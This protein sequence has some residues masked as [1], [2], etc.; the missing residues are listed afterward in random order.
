MFLL[1]PLR[2]TIETIDHRPRVGLVEKGFPPLPSLL[3]WCVKLFTAP[4]NI[5]GQITKRR[6]LQPG[7]RR[8]ERARRRVVSC[9]SGI[10]GR[11]NSCTTHRPKL[12]RDQS[13]NIFQFICFSFPKKK[14]DQD[15][16]SKSDRKDPQ[17]DAKWGCSVMF[18]AG[19]GLVA[20]VQCHPS[21]ALVH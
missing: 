19:T 14:Q 5:P 4:W 7:L 13:F 17:P 10:Q 9:S 8:M 18:M 21:Q 2:E 6:H 12:D 20:A 3:A 16:N 1:R 15:P 11:L